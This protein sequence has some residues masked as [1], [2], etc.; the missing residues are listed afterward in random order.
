MEK[1]KRVFT[2]DVGNMSAKEAKNF[3]EKLK[4]QFRKIKDDEWKIKVG[5]FGDG[6]LQ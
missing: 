1:G 5:D 2:I 3:V 6:R 4:E